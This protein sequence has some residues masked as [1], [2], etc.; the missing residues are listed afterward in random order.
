MC[1]RGNASSFPGV[2]G[3]AMLGGGLYY[4][5]LMLWCENV[6]RQRSRGGVICR[7][8]GQCGGCE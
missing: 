1:G 4:R 7:S 8:S 3:A 5:A 6:G 2:V